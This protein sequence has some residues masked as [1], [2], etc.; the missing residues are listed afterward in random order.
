MMK[1]KS[2]GMFTIR[3]GAPGRR[4]SGNYFQLNAQSNSNQWEM[5]CIPCT[6][7][8]IP[9]Y[10]YNKKPPQY[11]KNTINELQFLQIIFVYLRTEFLKS[12]VL[13]LKF[14][15]KAPIKLINSKATY[16]IHIY[17]CLIKFQSSMMFLV[18]NLTYVVA[19]Q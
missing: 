9:R 18:D 2:N 4:F 13:K 1:M 15:P 8:I 14:A 10:T 17:E 3:F 12:R 7:I 5:K 16:H 11:S 19:D 6:I